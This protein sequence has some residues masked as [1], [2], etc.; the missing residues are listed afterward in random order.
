[1]FGLFGEKKLKKQIENSSK[2][3]NCDYD[4]IWEI[5]DRNHF[6]IAISGWLC[7]KCN[8]GEDIENLTCAEKTFYF[9]TLF[10]S[11]VNN[12]G[13]SQF[14]YNSSGDFA[15]E[16]I[17]SLNIIGANKIA[18]IYTNAFEALG[19][20]IPTDRD[21]REKMLEN[22]I[23]DRVNKIFDECDNEFYAYPDHLE[24][25]NYQ[26]IMKNKGQFIR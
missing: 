18:E 7:Q 6:L 5:E 22:T 26:F 8:Y 10:E 20:D 13:F 2:P 17:N 14:L 23:T 11:E 19:G 12:G 4:D 15:N 24:E 21:Q 25:L 9:N 16:I 3:W 1:M